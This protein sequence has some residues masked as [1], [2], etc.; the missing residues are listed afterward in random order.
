[1]I[2]GI[3][4]ENR[5]GNEKG[6]ERREGGREEERMRQ[7]TREKRKEDE[8][9][10]SKVMEEQEQGEDQ[11]WMRESEKGAQTGNTSEHL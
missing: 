6:E 10:V 3:R 4:K 9:K 11:R 8:E 7:G 1:M 5:G 2:A